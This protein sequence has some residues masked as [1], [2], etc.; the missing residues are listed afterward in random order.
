MGSIFHNQTSR[1]ALASCFLGSGGKFRSSSFLLVTYP[2]SK[3]CT[4]AEQELTSALGG[5]TACA[6]LRMHTSE[7]EFARSGSKPPATRR[8]RTSGFLFECLLR[9]VAAPAFPS[10][11]KSLE[12]NIWKQ[13]QSQN[14]VRRSR[15][16]SRFSGGRSVLWRTRT[17]VKTEWR[18][19]NAYHPR[20]PQAGEEAS[21]K[22]CGRG[23]RSFRHRRARTPARHSWLPSKAMDEGSLAGYGTRLEKAVTI[24]DLGFLAVTNGSPL[25]GSMGGIWCHEAVKPMRSFRLSL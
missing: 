18:H 1:T 4:R 10:P 14:N 6:S 2:V 25:A 24:D 5:S 12:E 15:A 8:T 21:E 13:I 20:R 7:C 16:F 22:R 3:P 23:L 11:A 17:R 19:L 9:I